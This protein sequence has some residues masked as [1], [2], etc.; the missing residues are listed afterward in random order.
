VP[1]DVYWRGLTEISLIDLGQV[2]G[3]VTDQNQITDAIRTKAQGLIS[4]SVES[5]KKAVGSDSG[6]FQNW[7]ALGRVY[8]V[9]ASNGIG[10]SIESARINYAEAALRSPNNPSVPL[11]LARL[12]AFSGDSAGAKENIMK[13]LAL[14]NNYTDAYFTLAQIEVAENNIPGA[15]KSVEAAT[16]VDQNNVGLYFQLGLLKYNQKDWSGAA[17]AFERAIVLVPDYANAKYFLGLSYYQLGREEEA[18]KQFEKL[19]AT[20]PDNQEVILILSN[21]K[22]GK[23]VFSDAKPPIDNTPEKRAE[24]PVQGN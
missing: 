17:S 15:I 18:I 11:A 22:A 1:S 19:N 16:I 8:E 14:K 21:M 7:F 4:D 10:D 24:P 13:A 3:S 6:N 20:N 5:A 9:L 2:I 23:S 12:G